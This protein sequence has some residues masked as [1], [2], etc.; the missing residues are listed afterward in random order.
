MSDLTQ[1]SS[2]KNKRGLGRGLGSLLGQPVAHEAPAAPVK[3]VPKATEQKATITPAIPPEVVAT[4][5]TPGSKVWM[6]AIDKLKSGAYQPRKQFDKQPLEELSQSIKENGILQP[7]V[8]RKLEN[9]G[10]EIVAGERRWR[11][12]QLAGMHEVPVIIRNYENK[13]ALE[14]AIVENVQREDLNAIE[15]AQA[16]HRL[17]NEFALS[18][19]Q[20][21]EKVGKDRATVS[22]AIRL[23]SLSAAVREMIAQG[24]ISAG[25]AKVL[26]SLAD[27]QK[28]G[29]LAKLVK[30]EGLSVRALEKLV[31]KAGKET[32][33]TAATDIKDEARAKS[34][35]SLA[36]E[37]QKMLS[38]K[39][40]IDYKGGKGTLKMAFYSDEELNNLADVIK[41]G[42][43]K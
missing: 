13:K 27:T 18:H 26:L 33:E 9:N 22:N 19:Q 1:D 36:A 14:L 41:A 34:A 6:L 29:E 10:F 3:E 30:A 31:A 43:E 7:I 24:E 35:E 39:I 20:I 40:T 21:A 15:E 16:Y 11:A 5:E 32:D 2:N 28:Q 23:L 25:H 38:T 42:C 4:S 12:A 8:V 37:L 17:A